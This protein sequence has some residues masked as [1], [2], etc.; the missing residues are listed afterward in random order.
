MKSAEKR[1]L[2]TRHVDKAWRTN[3][4]W[5]IKIQEKRALVYKGLRVL[6]Q[7]TNVEKFVKLV[8]GFLIDTYSDDNKEFALYLE[9]FYVKRVNE[10]AYCYRKASFI[11]TNMYLESFHKTFKYYYLEGRKNKRLDTCIDALLK[12]F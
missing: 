7:E 8:E 3:L 1:L 11:N 4:Q 6:L 5:K 9:N 2:C 12:L 10:W